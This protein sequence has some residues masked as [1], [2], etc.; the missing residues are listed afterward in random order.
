LKA[1]IRSRTPISALKFYIT[2]L[3]NLESIEDGT[4]ALDSES[5]LRTTVG[6]VEPRPRWSFAEAKD[7]LNLP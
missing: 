4:V 7:S 3:L 2:V 6:T 1:E 5:K